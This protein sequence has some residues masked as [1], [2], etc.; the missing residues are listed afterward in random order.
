MNRRL[1]EVMH[2]GASVITFN[3]LAS[4]DQGRW[5]IQDRFT[6]F[7]CTDDGWWGRGVTCGMLI[8][9]ALVMERGV[10]CGILIQYVL[11]MEDGGQLWD[12]DPVC[13]VD[14]RESSVG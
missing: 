13:T 10:K 2:F 1:A 14:G 4:H 12:T 9:N 11:L 6:N 3:A 5:A 7:M 8:K